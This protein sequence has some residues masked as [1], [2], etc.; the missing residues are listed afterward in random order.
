[1]AF[2]IEELIEKGANTVKR[3][4]LLVGA[5][6]LGV[7][8]IV[9]FT[10]RGEAQVYTAAYEPAAASGE[11]MGAGAGVGGGGGDGVTL[12]DLDSL[13]ETM[14]D[15]MVGGLYANTQYTQE[16]FAKLA[17]N[18][19]MILSEQQAATTR[20]IDALAEKTPTISDFIGLLPSLVNLDGN[21]NAM[22]SS[23]TYQQ[24]ASLGYSPEQIND[25]I[26]NIVTTPG[27]VM[28]KNTQFTAADIIDI[29]QFASSQK[30][31]QAGG[32]AMSTEQISSKNLVQTWNPDGT[33]T[34]TDR[35]IYYGGNPPKSSSGGGSS[36]SQTA[37]QPKSSSGGGGV[38]VE[39]IKSEMARNSAAWAGASPEGKEALHSRNL[40][41]AS[42]IG[43]S[44]DSSSGTYS[45]S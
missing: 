37:S 5:G 2:E 45:F 42:K 41:L 18:T 24:A 28:N 4:P 10:G 14:Q 8:A 32:A 1:M 9:Y 44:F 15:N 3:N 27:I 35:D 21:T 13:L 7:A 16:L 11:L 20:Q 17:E 25:A 36:S 33:V 34:F 6:V 39:S 38:N 23:Q 29:S 12:G 19:A 31:A 40:E 22:L 43:G 30:A 26:A